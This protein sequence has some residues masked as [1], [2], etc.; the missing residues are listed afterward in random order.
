MRL[1]KRIF[2]LIVLVKCTAEAW[3]RMQKVNEKETLVLYK[4]TCEQK[5]SV[6]TDKEV[7]SQAKL[8]KI[9]W[10][11][12]VILTFVI[13]ILRL[14]TNSFGIVN[15]VYVAYF[16]LTHLEVDWFT[17][18]QIPSD[19]LC[20]FVVAFTI[21]INRIGFRVQLLLM[22][23]CEIFTCVCLICAYAH[24]SLYPLIYISQ[25]IMGIGLAN[26]ETVTPIL[27]A[28]WFP[29]HEVGT[30][31]SFGAISVG[32]GSVCAFIIPSQLFI[33]PNNTTMNFSLSSS[34]T[35]KSWF[36]QNQKRFLTFSGSILILCVILFIII[37][38]FIFEHPPSPPNVKSKTLEIDL[39]KQKISLN[40][41]KCFIIE[42][43]KIVENQTVILIT[44][45][46]TIR[47]SSY[48]V[49]ILFM[50]EILRDIF[51]DNYSVYNSNALAGYI[52]MI[53]QI[54]FSI[55]GFSS[56]LVY[57]KFKKPKLQIYCSSIVNLL[58]VFGFLLGYYLKMFLVL[59]CS[60]LIFGAMNGLSFCAYFGILL[61]Q[62]YSSNGAITIDLVKLQSFFCALVINQGCRFVLD[63]FG[64]ISVFVFIAILY[65]LLNFLN[66][67]L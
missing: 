57:D 52:L 32:V 17:L 34:Q 1:N 63:Y 30:A 6:K 65:L 50:S 4:E 10:F 11:I 27:T 61:K 29:K 33:S 45:I 47:I 35:E 49:L 15:N 54:G 67:F 5:K 9:R 55:G 31:L 7:S 36:E 39:K 21:Y 53:S 25:F 40:T 14:L 12:A 8:Y 38:L 26:S 16:N 60:S 24:P 56:G 28:N 22:T 66:I 18:I 62:T 3:H 48:Y 41:F 46:M 44:L 2:R 42:V 43:K 13:I 64:G 58:A 19:I 23:G 20:S 51:T 59:F 37:A